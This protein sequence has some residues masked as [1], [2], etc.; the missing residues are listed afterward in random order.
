MVGLYRHHFLNSM[1][2]SKEHLELLRL[3][4]RN[5]ITEKELAHRLGVKNRNTAILRIWRVHK[6]K[7][8][9][10]SKR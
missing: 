3:A 2:L 6:A 7:L 5:Q 4:E 10:R 8:A 9:E 1:T